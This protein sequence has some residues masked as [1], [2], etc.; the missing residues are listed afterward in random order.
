MTISL[1]VQNEELS[2]EIMEAPFSEPFLTRRIK[3]LSRPDGF[4]FYGKLGVVF[5]STSGLLY[6][7]KKL[8]YD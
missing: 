5:F 6:P 3:M 8:G 1:A 4:M 2:D 7:N